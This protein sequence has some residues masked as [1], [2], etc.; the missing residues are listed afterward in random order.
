MVRIV[1][2]AR[3]AARVTIKVGK[4]TLT[5]KSGRTIVLRRSV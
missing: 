4:A 2:K 1:V 5:L 3:R